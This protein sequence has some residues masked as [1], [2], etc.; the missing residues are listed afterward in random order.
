VG[1]LENYQQWLD[2]DYRRD[3]PLS[4]RELFPALSRTGV[5]TIDDYCG[6]RTA[7]LVQWAKIPGLGNRA[8][9]TFTYYLLRQA[10]RAEL[11]SAPLHNE[12]ERLIVISR[13]RTERHND[14]DPFATKT[15]RPITRKQLRLIRQWWIEHGGGQG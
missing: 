15:L 9:D 13:L 14:L 10:A 12:P 8:A 6:L 7:L 1:R 4:M 11:P 2:E 3:L 5:W